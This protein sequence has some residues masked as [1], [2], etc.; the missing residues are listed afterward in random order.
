MCCGGACSPFLI[1]MRYKGK[2]IDITNNEEGE[3]EVQVT[4]DALRPDS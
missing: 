3:S 1:L 2:I 4:G